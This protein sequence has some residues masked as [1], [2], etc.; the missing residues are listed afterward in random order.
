MLYIGTLFQ[1]MSAR[2]NTRQQ[3][4]SGLHSSCRDAQGPAS[5]Q[6]L[7]TAWPRLAY[8]ASFTFNAHGVT[9]VVHHENVGKTYL[10]DN[11]R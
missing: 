1:N 5:V 2:G 8:D 10:L 6:P 4:R 7:S 11:V 3:Q 9:S